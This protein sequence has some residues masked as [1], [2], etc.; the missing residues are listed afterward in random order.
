MMNEAV[1][2][3][4]EYIIVKYKE[5]EKKNYETKKNNLKERKEKISIYKRALNEQKQ[6]LEA[7]CKNTT[8]F[9]EKLKNIWLN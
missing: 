1:Q 3:G 7:L 8:K 5:R 4:A 6:K 2:N 9:R